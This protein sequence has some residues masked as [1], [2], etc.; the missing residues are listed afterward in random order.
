MHL[1]LY[2]IKNPKAETCT[3]CYRG[4]IICANGEAQALSYIDMRMEDV[5]QLVVK[6]IGKAVSGLAPGIVLDDWVSA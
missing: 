4:W 2:L 1:Y 3:D 5:K 6:Y